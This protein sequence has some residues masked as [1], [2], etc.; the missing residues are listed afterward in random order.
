MTHLQQ[1]VEGA[2]HQAIKGFLFDGKMYHQA[3]AALYER[4]GQEG[5]VSQAYLNSMFSVHDSSTFYGRPR[6]HGKVQLGSQQR[7]HDAAH[8]WLPQ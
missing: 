1:A 7:R 5:D 6:V 2:A 8:S 4:F 3:L